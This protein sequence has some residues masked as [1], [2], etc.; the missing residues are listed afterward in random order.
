MEK[1][2]LGYQIFALALFAAIMILLPLLTMINRG[3]PQVKMVTA[4]QGK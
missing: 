2:T 3:D 4:S 1:K